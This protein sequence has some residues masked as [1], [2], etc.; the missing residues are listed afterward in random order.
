MLDTQSPFHLML[1]PEVFSFK[2]HFVGFKMLQ[3]Y[4]EQGVNRFQFSN[5]CNVC[6]VM[7]CRICIYPSW[8]IFLK[9]FFQVI[10]PHDRMIGCVLVKFSSSRIHW[11]V[12]HYSWLSIG[13]LFGAE[14]PVLKMRGLEAYLQPS[15]SFCM[16]SSVTA[17]PTAGWIVLTETSHS[18]LLQINHKSQSQPTLW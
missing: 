17:S 1:Q 8:F 6:S 10:L 13:E 11:R 4:L 16:W 5:K 15:H 14:M 12:F 3:F 9:T 18:F 2:L 7:K